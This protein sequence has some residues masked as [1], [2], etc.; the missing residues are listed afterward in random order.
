MRQ[1]DAL[2]VATFARV[3]KEAQ[4]FGRQL[5]DTQR[6]AERAGYQVVDTIAEKL[7]GSRST[8][9][10]RSALDQF[11]GLAKA[12]RIRMVLVTEMS[13]LGRRARETR[14]MV[15]QLAD[16][17][18]SV[19]ALNIQFGYLSARWGGELYASLNREPVVSREKRIFT[20]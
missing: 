20:T 9:A 16:L 13:W 11:M 2:P 18:V 10:R 7:S 12:G 17:G 15:G 19:F 3:S 6:H 5:I 14:A 1:N 8:R 4:D